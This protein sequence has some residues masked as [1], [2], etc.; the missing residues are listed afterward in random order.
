MEI[1]D[2]FTGD[3]FGM[4][5]L[6]AAVNKTPFQP[7]FLGTLGIF[8]PAPIRTVD[9][10][11]AMSDMGDL[12][13][14]PTT[15]RGSPPVE[16]TVPTQNVRSFRTPRVAIGDT[17]T[18]AELQGILAR[19]VMM[20]VDSAV[21]L[22]DMQSEI[23]FRLDGPV[24]LRAKVETTKERM[25]L[26]A[27][28]GVVLDKDG[29]ILYDWPTQFGI[30]LPAEVNFNLKA[31]SPVPGA[32]ATAVRQLQRRVLRAAKAG[33]QPAAAVIGLCG[34]DFFDALVSHPDVMP[35]YNTFIG[36]QSARL[37]SPNPNI[38]AFSTFNWSGID[39]VNYRGTDDQAAVAIDPSKVKFVVSGVPGLFQ[40]VLAPA[41]FADFFNELGRPIYAMILP[42]PS[43][44]KAYVRL[45]VYSYPMYMATRPDVLFSGRM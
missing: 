22:Q 9:A 14:V 4:V 25:R 39:W 36:L 12:A 31:A 5:T 3:A 6:T 19:S 8:T 28:S 18:V 2:I 10:A 38:P 41:E 34:D 32:L 15:A 40:E 26:G 33:N 21:V 43:G 17:I 37:S 27:I 16:Q 42:D 24:G 11:V 44:R 30:A 1:M 13:I 29:S 23:A 35:A 45:E 20:G 7:E